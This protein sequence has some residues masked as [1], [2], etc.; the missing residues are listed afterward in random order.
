MLDGVVW[1]GVNCLVDSYLRVHLEDEVVLGFTSETLNEASWVQVA[2]EQ[3]GVKI[4]KVWMI[5][6]RDPEFQARLAAVLPQPSALR[7]NLLILTLERETLSH[8]EI[9]QQALRAY[10]KSR[11]RVCRAITASGLL[12]SDGLRVTPE[13]LS[14]RNTALLERLMPAK[15]IRVTSAAGTDLQ[16]NFN[17]EKYRW[18]SN[19]GVWQPGKIMILPA[20]EV[21]TYPDEIEGVFV[22]DFAFNA[23]ITTTQDPRLLHSPVTVWIERGRAVRYECSDDTLKSFLDSCFVK[24]CSFRVGEV[25]FGTNFGVRKPVALNS[26]LNERHTG[27]HL[28]FGESNQAPHVVG[29]ECATHLDLISS[30]G[31][32]WIDCEPIPIDLLDVLPSMSEHPIETRDEDAF[33]SDGTNGF[34]SDDCCSVVRIFA[35]H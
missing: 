26:H 5:P 25:G 30:G 13:D 15:T 33:S 31:T 1:R 6:L 34:D 12:F 35:R 8:D 19:R 23:N 18:I 7:G 2:L 14:A 28:G 32:V 4:T 21:A 27:V 3:R 20:G 11:V 24:D 10:P 22:A 9:L 29:Y 16:I 17:P